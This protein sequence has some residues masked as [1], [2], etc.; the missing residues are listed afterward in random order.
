MNHLMLQR[1]DTGGKTF[2]VVSDQDELLKTADIDLRRSA[3]VEEL[4]ID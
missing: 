2:F 4:V 1:R 3:I